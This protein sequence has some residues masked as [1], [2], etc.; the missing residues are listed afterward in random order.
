[1]IGVHLATLLLFAAPAAVPH[2]QEEE[3]VEEVAVAEAQEPQA[4]P[5][6]EAEVAKESDYL[7]IVGGDIYTITQGVVYRGTVLCKEDRIVEIGERVRI[8]E[9]A[10]VIDA[11]G[12]RVYPGLVNVGSWGIVSSSMPDAFDPYSL[13]LELGLAGGIT[14]TLSGNIIAKLTHGTLDGCVLGKSPIIKLTYSSTAPASRRKLREQLGKARAFLRERDDY[15]RALAAGEEGLEEPEPKGVSPGHLALLEGTKT[16]QFSATTVKDLNAVVDL[17]Q[18]YPMKAIVSGARA[19]WLV[20]DRLGRAGVSAIVVPR[21][22]QHA[23]DRLSRPSGWS[24]ENASKLHG[25]GVR[26]AINTAS[27]R[28]STMGLAG[29][30]LL[31]LPMEAAFAVRGGLPAEDAVR[32]ITINAADML[33]FGHRIGSIEVGK[34]ADLIVCDGDLLDYRTFVQWA[35][36]NGRVA[37]DKQEMPYFAHIRPRAGGVEEVVDPTA[38]PEEAPAEAELEEV[39]E[40]AVEEV[41]PNE[42]EV[43][44][45]PLPEEPSLLR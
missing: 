1:M 19:G 24:I 3:P 32:A 5:E 6:P 14:T 13:S 4:A 21:S 29:R 16:A 18:R 41:D 33:G 34:D 30:D 11:A 36:V 28:I 25:A 22:K 45:E 39:V 38:L 9:G 12:M 42:E 37:Y 26:L 17:L 2:P 43:V 7:A 20:A 31:T 35:V 40:E 10:K 15:N 27:A 23:D 8:P 44:D